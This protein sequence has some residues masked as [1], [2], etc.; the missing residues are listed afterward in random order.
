MIPK[1]DFKSSMNK[2][3]SQISADLRD[4]DSS[5]ANVLDAMNFKNLINAE[6]KETDKSRKK[7]FTDFLNSEEDLQHIKKII[8][9]GKKTSSWQKRKEIK[10]YLKDINDIDDFLKSYQTHLTSKK[11]ETKEATASGSAGQYSS[12]FSGEMKET[13]KTNNKNVKKIPEKNTKEHSQDDGESYTKTKKVETKEATSSASS[14][15]YSTNKV[16][17]KSMNKKD[18]RGYSK[19]QLPGGKFV[20]VKKKCK[21]FPYC[22]QGDINALSLF[23][24]KSL[25]KVIQKISSERNIHEDIIYQVILDELNKTNINNIYK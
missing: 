20:R 6:L 18:F 7:N 12:L 3:F 9:T 1:P 4:S 19:P 13:E 23:E 8:S 2:S 22:N 16:W 25:Q 5:G 24:N 14:G 17:A 15:Q 11:E 10:K 21:K